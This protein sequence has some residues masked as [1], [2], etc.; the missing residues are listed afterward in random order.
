MVH[1]EECKHTHI[2]THHSIFLSGCTLYFDV[3]EL[4]DVPRWIYTCMLA[5]WGVPYLYAY[6]LLNNAFEL[7]W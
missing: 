4:G 6:V 3:D 5:S 2:H 7:F 1:K